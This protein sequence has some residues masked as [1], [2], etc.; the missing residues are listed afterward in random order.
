ML[1]KSLIHTGDTNLT[2]I[3]WIIVRGLNELNRK[4]SGI[5]TFYIIV[6][7]KEW[8]SIDDYQK[9]KDLKGLS[10]KDINK[11]INDVIKKKNVLAIKN[12]TNIP[13]QIND[14][15]VKKYIEKLNK[16]GIL[17]DINFNTKDLIG[18]SVLN[19]QNI[20]KYFK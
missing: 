15:T 10:K 20:I 18:F 17:L 8:L 14:V 16:L 19:D 1:E 11:K 9:L 12:N 2:E 5:K 3:A 7:S 4:Y 6:V 13:D